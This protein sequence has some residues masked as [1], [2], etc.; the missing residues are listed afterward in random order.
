MADSYGAAS[1]VST[2]GG[3]AIIANLVARRSVIL[4]NNGTAI[5]YVVLIRPSHRLRGCL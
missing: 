3:T 4:K 2:A 1:V 5:V